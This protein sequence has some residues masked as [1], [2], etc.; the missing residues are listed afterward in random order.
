M[1]RIRCDLGAALTL[2][3]LAGPVLPASLP[4]V[5]A[6]F[7]LEHLVRGTVKNASPV[8]LSEDALALLVR[9][10]ERPGRSKLAV[11][12]LA[13]GQLQILAETDGGYQ[14]DR[15]FSVSNGRLLIAGARQKILYAQDLRQKMGLGDEGP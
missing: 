8:F 10:A 1:S 7:S 9:S 3:L 14:G 13:N 15:I 4:P 6:R 2:L 12:R 5:V 11:L